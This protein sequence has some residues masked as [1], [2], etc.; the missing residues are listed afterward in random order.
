M[1]LHMIITIS[2]IFVG[3]VILLY[4]IICYDKLKKEEE[5]SLNSKKVASSDEEKVLDV[6]NDTSLIKEKS[7]D[8]KKENDISLVKEVDKNEEKENVTFKDNDEK[9]KK[10]IL[11]VKE[12]TASKITPSNPRKETKE[13]SDFMAEEDF[14]NTLVFDNDKSIEPTIEV[15]SVTE[16]PSDEKIASDVE[17]LFD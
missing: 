11:D 13:I 1:D 16:I 15:G 17:D 9:K 10:K 6:K 7:E 14:E 12:T 8:V 5:D 4:G 2:G 3:M